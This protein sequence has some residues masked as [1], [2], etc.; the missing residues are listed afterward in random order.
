MNKVF[1]DSL[2]LD[3]LYLVKNTPMA[4]NIRPNTTHNSSRIS[5]NKF[6]RIENNH[7]PLKAIPK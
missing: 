6:N 5:G 3:T 1:S 7:I 4:K 2:S